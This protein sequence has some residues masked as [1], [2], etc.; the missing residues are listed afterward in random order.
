MFL[1]ARIYRSST[2]QSFYNFCK[3]FETA[4]NIIVTIFS[5]IYSSFEPNSYIE[6]VQ[7]QWCRILI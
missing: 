7:G 1:A 3:Y 4:R 5:V 6:F 2:K